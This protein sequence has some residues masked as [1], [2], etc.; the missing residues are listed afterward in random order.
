MA[1]VDSRALSLDLLKTLVVFSDSGTVEETARRLGMT[2]AGVSLQ[3]K[4]LEEQIGEPLFRPLGR[5]KALT[6]FARD[7]CQTVAPPLN[8]LA[9]RLEEA[10]R[11]VPDPSRRTLR[12]GGRA[13][14]FPQAIERIEFPGSITLQAMTGAEALSALRE[15]RL[16]LAL[17]TEA[18][19][20][21]EFI[22]KF[23]F[24]EEIV[25]AFPP[26]WKKMRSWEDVEKDGDFLAKPA[27]GYKIDPPF[28][29]E[30]AA[31]LGGK[32]TLKFVC[33]DW[34]GVGRFISAGRAWAAMP[35]SA[36]PAGCQTVPLPSR[37]VKPVKFHAV[38]GR[39]E[40][41]LSEFIRTN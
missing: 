32:F 7:L 12:V 21:L 26:A 8:E 31:A 40:R 6:D 35:A 1:L 10:A 18:P 29:S 14:I 5:K 30:I 16:D 15:D 28:L 37:V 23:F 4:K 20:S 34:N 25:L 19:E 11:R 38:Y 24:Q 2:Q 33:E 27:A 17:L 3:L 9:Q 39:H 22:S 13:E 36:V 41:G